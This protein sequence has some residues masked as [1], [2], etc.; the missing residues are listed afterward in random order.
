[1]DVSEL[2]VDAAAETISF[3]TLVDVIVVQQKRIELIE[4]RIKSKSPTDRLDQAD[5]EGSGKPNVS[6]VLQSIGKQLGDFMLE[7]ML[8]RSNALAPAGSQLF[9]CDGNPLGALLDRLMIDAEKA[10]PVG[11]A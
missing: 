5:T 2:K 1:M 7:S 3:A 6:S 10:E 9:Q 4:A 8:H 11:L